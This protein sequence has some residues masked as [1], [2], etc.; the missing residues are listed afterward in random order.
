MGTTGE[1]GRSPVKV[2]PAVADHVAAFQSCFGI[3]LAL[4]AAERDACGQGVPMSLL[5]GQVAM[6]ANF[7]TAT[8][9]T[10]TG[11]PVPFPSAAGL[12]RMSS[13]SQARPTARRH[14]HTLALLVTLLTTAVV[15]FC[16]RSV[17]R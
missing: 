8:T 3:M 14:A 6:L 15:S 5:D 12:T 13:Q 9:G 1:K 17:L 11:P 2:A 10:W 16:A 7:V 4:R